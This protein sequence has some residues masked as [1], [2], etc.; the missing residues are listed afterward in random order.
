MWR[1]PNKLT[2]ADKYMMADFLTKAG[3]GRS[4]T[5]NKHLEQQHGNPHLAQTQPTPATMHSGPILNKHMTHTFQKSLEKALVTNT[6]SATFSHRSYS[7]LGTLNL[8]YTKN[9]SLHRH[10]KTSTTTQNTETNTTQPLGSTKHNT[11]S[12]H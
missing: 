11:S 5:S 7:K 1:G 3:M 8:N 4:Y 10:L 12:K 2:T 9:I 6:K